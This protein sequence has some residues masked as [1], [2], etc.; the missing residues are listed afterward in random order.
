MSKV[1]PAVVKRLPRYRRLLEELKGKDVVR[2]SSEKLGEMAGCT[3]SQ[4]RQDLNNFGGFGSQGY[5]YNVDALLDRLGEILG[6]ENHFTMVV[7]G[8]G[9]LGRAITNFINSYDSEFEIKAI[10]DVSPDE[11]GGT[12]CGLKV[13]DAELLGE[14]LENNATDIGVI[15]VSGENAQGVADTLAA[16][17]IKGIWN[18][19]ISE[20][21]ISDGIAIQNVRISDSLHTLSFYISSAPNVQS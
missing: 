16:G 21:K 4:V 1:S 7:V 13:M 18:F 17:G 19:T 15:T 14:Y 10:F 11:T 12:V 6:L 3:A 2:I 5:G 20:L 9:N 8:V